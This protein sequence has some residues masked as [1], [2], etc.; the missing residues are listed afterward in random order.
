M[1]KRYVPDPSAPKPATGYP[2]VIASRAAFE[3]YG[4]GRFDVMLAAARE[5]LDGMRADTYG[6]DTDE[7]GPGECRVRE[8]TNVPARTLGLVGLHLQKW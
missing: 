4:A 6:S 8:M 5:G 1:A 2:V 3:K 7:P